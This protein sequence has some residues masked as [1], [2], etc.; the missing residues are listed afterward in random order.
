[1]S[2]PHMVPV[3]PTSGLDLRRYGISKSQTAAVAKIASVSIRKPR[4]DQFIRVDPDLDKRIWVPVLEDKRDF[5]TRYF[6]V[7]EDIQA[8][9]AD[10]GDLAVRLLVPTVTSLGSFFLWVINVSERNGELTGWASSAMDA[11]NQATSLWIRVI[12]DNDEGCYTTFAAQ[13]Q[14]ALGQPKFP[15]W[16]TDKMIEMAF[17]DKTIDSLDHPLVKVRTGRQLK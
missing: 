4:K 12:A 16:D 15:D 10:S 14:T 8:A 1:M 2:T 3:E 6:L 11:V 17:K 9:L 7:A 13:N 5:E